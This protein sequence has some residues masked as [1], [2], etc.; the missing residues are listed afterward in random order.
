MTATVLAKAS[1]VSPCQ[2]HSTFM[3]N[4]AH[5]LFGG[6]YCLAALVNKSTF[7]VYNKNPLYIQV[8]IR[9]AR[10]TGKNANDHRPQVLGQ[11]ETTTASL[12]GDVGRCYVI[13]TYVES[14]AGLGRRASRP[15]NRPT[16]VTGPRNQ[17]RALE[18]L[19]TK[20]LHRMLSA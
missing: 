12:S 8:K 20:I 4:N 2:K 18:R 17:Y 11:R 1:S 16:A 13:L 14:R 3:R 10:G 19:R 9:P 7:Y 5:L 6:R 15:L